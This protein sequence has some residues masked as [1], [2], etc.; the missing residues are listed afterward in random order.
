MSRLHLRLLLFFPLPCATQST[1]TNEDL[2]QMTEL[3]VVRHIP[4]NYINHVLIKKENGGKETQLR[5]SRL[6]E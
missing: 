5:S 4:Q 3:F 1:Q 2:M 6:T